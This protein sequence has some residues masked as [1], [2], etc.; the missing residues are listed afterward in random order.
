MKRQT[1]KFR[2]IPSFIVKAWSKDG[3]KVFVVDRKGVRNV[4]I[5]EAFIENVSLDCDKDEFERY[6]STMTEFLEEDFEHGLTIGNSYGNVLFAELLSYELS[7]SRYGMFRVKR[8][9][10]C[11]KEG[12]YSRF[13]RKIG[14]RK[15][16]EII[17]DIS[18]SLIEGMYLMDFKTALLEAPDGFEFI[19]GDNPVCI[20]NPLGFVRQFPLYAHGTM[21]IMPYSPD[22]AFCLYDSSAY[23]LRKTDDRIVL[24]ED[25]V[26][27]INTYAASSGTSFVTTDPERYSSGY[28]LHIQNDVPVYDIETELSPVRI[29]AASLDFDSMDYRQFVHALIEY[30]S[31]HSSAGGIVEI[32]TE[33]AGDRMDFISRYLLSH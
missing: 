3:S 9:P 21:F 13:L 28:C 25:D 23:K 24:S 4:G 5:D 1:A 29:L 18:Y 14:E 19:L 31:A 27:R 20:L 26:E 22:R 12:D 8:D 7:A 10:R 33:T 32:G 30:D 6:A 15:A 2:N 11:V 16:S 17:N